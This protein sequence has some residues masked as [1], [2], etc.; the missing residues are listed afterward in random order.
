MC[1]VV[2]V[3]NNDVPARFVNQLLANGV[4]RSH[5]VHMATAAVNANQ[6]KK[7]GKKVAVVINVLSSMTR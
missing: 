3:F 7:K 1:A 4:S 6:R 2:V 5:P